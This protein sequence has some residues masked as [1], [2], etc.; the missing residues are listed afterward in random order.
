MLLHFLLIGKSDPA[1]FFFTPNYT[2]RL[3]ERDPYQTANDQRCLLSTL[4]SSYNPRK[5]EKLRPDGTT[6]RS[7]FVTPEITQ[8]THAELN[9]LRPLSRRCNE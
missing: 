1:L 3:Q 6:Q 5:Q 9:K 7:L 4:D 8:V 2:L